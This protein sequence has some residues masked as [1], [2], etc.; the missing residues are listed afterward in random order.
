MQ[1]IIDSRLF[2]SHIFTCESFPPVCQTQRHGT[3]LSGRKP[4]DQT[5]HLCPDAPHELSHSG[6]VHAAQVQLVL[7]NKTHDSASKNISIKLKGFRNMTSILPHYMVKSMVEFLT[8]DIRR[9][10]EGL[11]FYK[12]ILHI[13]L[14][15]Y[16]LSHSG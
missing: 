2:F 13:L 6:T 3:N 5:F 11:K 14:S 8:A 1:L 12:T 9:K 4:S 7:E 16:K 15:P 10:Q